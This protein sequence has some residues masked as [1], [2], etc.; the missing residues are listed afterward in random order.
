MIE[1]LEALVAVESPSADDAATEAAARLVDDLF[2]QHLG[3]RGTWIA[4]GRRGHLLWSGGGD[5]RVVLVGHVDTVWPFGTTARWP[6][7]VIDGRASG[8]GAFDM[9]AGLVQG[10]HALSALDDLAGV[11][12]LVTTDEEVGSPTSRELI[13]KTAQGARAALVLEPSADAALKSAR[14]GVSMYELVVHGRAAHA[15]LEPEKGANA[16]VELAHQVLAMLEVA[17]A[18][19]GTTVTPTV[20]SA[21]TTTNTVP[22]F[23]RVAVD[24]RAAEPAEQQ[25]VDAALRSLVARTPGTSLELRGGPNRPP[26]A[27]SS[28]AELVLRARRI[29][30]DL[31]LPPLADVAVGGGSDGNFTAGIGVPTLDGLGAVGAGAHA[32]GEHV[33]VEAMPQRA[34]LVTGLVRELLA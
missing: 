23:A 3:S 8:P 10:M 20:A 31:H 28:S 30:Q 22:A 17:D 24:V 29:A 25:R 16:A 7:T 4:D 32:E 1:E 15:G 6:F 9:K 27:P 33:L 18:A 13:E 11:R 21:G 14:K 26:L 12:F 34:A 5:T 19:V 2:L